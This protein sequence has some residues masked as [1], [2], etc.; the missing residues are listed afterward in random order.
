MKPTAK[1]INEPGNV[2]IPIINQQIRIKPLSAGP[3]NAA[4]IVS[5][6]GALRMKP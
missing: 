2:S 5:A 6:N 4:S 1:S 3:V